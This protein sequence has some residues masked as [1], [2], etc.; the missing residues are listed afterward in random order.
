MKT[1]NA[2]W[3]VVLVEGGIPR[4]VWLKSSYDAAIAKAKQIVQSSEFGRDDDCVQVFE[5]SLNPI[6][7][8]TALLSNGTI[9][10]W[11]K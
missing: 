11:L 5:T 6:N 2:R 9:D 10:K 8:G 7:S 4:S 1:Y 3:V